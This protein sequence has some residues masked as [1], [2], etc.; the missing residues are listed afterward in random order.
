[1]PLF[2]VYETRTTIVPAGESGEAEGATAVRAGAGIIIA[3]KWTRY[4]R[5]EQTKTPICIKLMHSDFVVYKI[6][7]QMSDLVTTGGI[8]ENCLRSSN[9]NYKPKIDA[10]KLNMLKLHC[11]MVRHEVNFA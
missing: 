2:F 11:V 5:R 9:Q 3:E 6:I 1:M 4:S 10:Q 7:K 8:L